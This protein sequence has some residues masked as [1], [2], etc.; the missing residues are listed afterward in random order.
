MHVYNKEVEA[1]SV[2]GRI[3][4]V[5]DYLKT[6]SQKDRIEVDKHRT[7]LRQEVGDK[8]YEAAIKSLGALQKV[9]NKYDR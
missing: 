1:F 4:S 6:V 5:H 2:M 9:L 7:A 8:D 3:G